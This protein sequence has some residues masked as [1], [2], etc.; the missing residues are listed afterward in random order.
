MNQEAWCGFETTHAGAVIC[1]V[2]VVLVQ[3][4]LWNFMPPE[5]VKCEVAD[6][7]MGSELD[8]LAT[9]LPSTYLVERVPTRPPPTGS[10]GSMY[11]V[12]R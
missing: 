7:M 10:G 5:T 9:S 1:L 12:R 4:G 8:I 3:A 2:V 11:D 6:T